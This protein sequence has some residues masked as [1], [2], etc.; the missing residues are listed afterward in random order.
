MSLDS[1]QAIR[2]RLDTVTSKLLDGEISTNVA[3]T[4]RKLLA[5]A[6]D[7]FKADASTALAPTAP[8][9]APTVSGTPPG[10]GATFNITFATTPNGPVFVEAPTPA[11]PTHP[12]P[13]QK[14]TPPHRAEAPLGR[15]DHPRVIDVEAVSAPPPPTPPPSP[16]P[17]P[18]PE[19]R[20]QTT[21]A[22]ERK[23]ATAHLLARYRKT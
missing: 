22:A 18:P 2:D 20:R 7:T 14:E 5:T 9:T 3:E 19:P 4:A 11:E 23:Q 10:G 17:T 8:V 16:P 1:P 13:R 6:A 21:Q 12:P 15:A